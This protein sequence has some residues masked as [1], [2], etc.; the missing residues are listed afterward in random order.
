MYNYFSIYCHQVDIYLVLYHLFVRTSFGRKLQ[1]SGKNMYV[2]ITVV[3]LLSF[4]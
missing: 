2:T 3:T 1:S 4:A